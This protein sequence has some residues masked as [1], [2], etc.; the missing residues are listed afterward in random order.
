MIAESNP[1]QAGASRGSRAR[2]RGGCASTDSGATIAAKLDAYL[3]QVSG[4]ADESTD[5]GE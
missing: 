4:R 3:E 5:E 2:T 1:Q